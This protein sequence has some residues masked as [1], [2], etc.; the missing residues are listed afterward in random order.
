[1]KTIF[2]KAALSNLT[3]AVLVSSLAVGLFMSGTAVAAFFKATEINASGSTALTVSGIEY[4]DP[5]CVADGPGS[6]SAG[7]SGSNVEVVFDAVEPVTTLNISVKA[8]NT[9]ATVLRAD[10][11]PPSVD[12]VVCTTAGVGDLD[13]VPAE[14]KT[15]AISCAFTASLVPGSIESFTINVDWHE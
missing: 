13:P 9:T 15:L 1:M 10:I 3:V 14:G 2:W 11:T 6:C 7:L 12:W 5:A 8:T 4:T